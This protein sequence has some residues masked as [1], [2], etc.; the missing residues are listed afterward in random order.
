MRRRRPGVSPEEHA[1]WAHVARQAK[2]LPGKRPLPPEAPASAQG[3][4]V[5]AAPPRMPPAAPTPAKPRLPPLSGIEPRLKRELRRGIAP[6]EA[7]LDLHGM[8]QAEAHQALLAFIH[9]AQ[10]QGVRL[11]LVITGKG[12]PGAL[13]EERGVLRRL[14]PH[15]LAD[16]ALRR[17]VLGYEPAGPGHGGEGALYVRIRRARARLA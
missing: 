12:A 17:C 8:R 15:W 7:R 10:H 13:A 9:R 11:A 14:V 3:E 5:A 2:P 16:P 1:L 4:P 6:V